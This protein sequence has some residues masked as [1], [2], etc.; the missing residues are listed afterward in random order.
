MSR[1]IGLPAAFRWLPRANQRGFTLIEVLVAF[2]IAALLLVAVLR[3]LTLGLAGTDR[4]DA[5]TRATILAESALDTL[6]VVTPLAEGSA[7]TRKGRFIIAVA[8]RR[9]DGSGAGNGQYLVLYRLTAKVSWRE[10]ARQ[11]SVS[12]ATLRLGPQP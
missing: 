6:G 2:A 1:L 5:Y 12:L 3:I 10:G 11:R 7:E 8:V 4:A 9:Y